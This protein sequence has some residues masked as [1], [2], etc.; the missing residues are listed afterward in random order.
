MAMSRTKKKQYSRIKNY[1]LLLSL[2]Q[3]QINF[4]IHN[5]CDAIV[6]NRKIKLLMIN[7]R[8][9]IVRQCVTYILLAYQ[10]THIMLQTK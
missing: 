9:Q 1:D 3:S 5:N 8:K 10:A 6:V 4:A 2:I 7:N